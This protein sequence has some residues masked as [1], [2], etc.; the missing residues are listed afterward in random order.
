MTEHTVTLVDEGTVE[1]I[2]VAADETILEAAEAA[3]VELE[4]SCRMGACTSCVGRL[5]EG[6]VD[7]SAATGLDPTQRDDGYALMCVSTPK[8]DCR[9]EVGVQ[10]ELFELP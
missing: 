5:I 10:D 2:S 1:R 7:Q 8:T 6:R 4:H 9:I 3:G